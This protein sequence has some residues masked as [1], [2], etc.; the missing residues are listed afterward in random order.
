MERIFCFRKIKKLKKV[1]PCH[2]NNDKEL[3]LFIEDSSAHLFWI[4]KIRGTSQE[5]IY[6]KLSSIFI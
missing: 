6:E 2:I 5:F 1:V 4:N 3:D